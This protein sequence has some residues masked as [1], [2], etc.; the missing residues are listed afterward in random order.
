MKPSVK[1]G[2]ILGAILVAVPLIIYALS[3]DKNET[4]QKVTGFL[5][6][7]IVAT[8]I[9]LGI[10]ETRDVHGNGFITFGSGFSTGMVIT[11]IGS[12]I[13]AVGT[14]LYFT[15]INPGM[16]TYIK[17]KQEEE[18]FARGM[19]DADVEKMADTM[20]S[21]SS[22]GMMTGM[23]LLVM[24]FLGLIVSLICAG[25]LKKEDPS[26]VIS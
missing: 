11:L 12:V 16:L 6:V 1:F 7:A 14:Y 8:I 15:V 5:N 10:R 4:L 22:P 25:I 21:F 2:L 13:S 18:L 24:I 20:A 9:F 23:A 19:S 17:M 26:Q 3:M